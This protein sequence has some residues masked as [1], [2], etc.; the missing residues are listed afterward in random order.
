MQNNDWLIFIPFCSEETTEFID[1]LPFV[2]QYCKFRKIIVSEIYKNF[3][4]DFLW[5]RVL[6]KWHKSLTTEL[7]FELIIH[8]SS[9][10]CLAQP[11]SSND[12][13]YLPHP[14]VGA[15]IPQLGY[16]N[17]PPPRGRVRLHLV[18]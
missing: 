13:H 15:I 5:V 3:L 9:K 11:T 6:A 17:V 7:G 4:E 12:R 14:L 10:S 2:H 18:A 1:K 16:C 8:R